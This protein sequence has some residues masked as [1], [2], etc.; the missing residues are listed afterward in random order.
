MINLRRLSALAVLVACLLT[1]GCSW[2]QK[3]V[4]PVVKPVET[5]AGQQV[6][7][8]N[9]DRALADLETQNYADLAAEGVAIGWDVLA[10]LID[11]I[12]SQK[13]SLKPAGDEF[14]RQNAEKIKAAQAPSVS[15]KSPGAAVPPTPPPALAFRKGMLGVALDSTKTGERPALPGADGTADA[16]ASAGAHEPAGTPAGPAAS[17]AYA[18]PP[19]SVLAATCIRECG[20]QDAVSTPDGCM[21]L[22]GHGVT[23][24]WV[25][26]R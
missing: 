1:P 20:S 7:A 5:C 17:F 6:S 24:R 3:N 9:F 25:A 19:V 11:D 16:T 12:T 23:S 2:F 8:A 18:G 4:E 13:P 10:C 15:L 22:L 14:K 26:A 21:C